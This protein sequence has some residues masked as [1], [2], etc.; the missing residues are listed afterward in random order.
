VIADV[1]LDLKYAA[2]AL[3]SQPAFLAGGG[4][5]KSQ[6]GHATSEPT[7]GHRRPQQLNT[8]ESG[9]GFCLQATTTGWY[10]IKAAC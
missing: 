8:E 9:R 4:A 3:K 7:A 10:G 2:R 5:E 1:L 6:D